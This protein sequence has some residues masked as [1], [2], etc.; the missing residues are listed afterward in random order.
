MYG[1][2]ARIQIK[3]GAEAQLDQLS[4]DF[5]SLKIPGFIASYV[6]QTGPQECYLTVLFDSRQSYVANAE[7]PEQNARFQEMRA[8]FTADPEWHDGEI[9]SAV[10]PG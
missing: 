3:P 2:V 4:R 9:I 8:L 5:G 7:S 6:Y 1:T 10:T